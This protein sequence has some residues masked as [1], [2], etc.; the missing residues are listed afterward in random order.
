MA[1]KYMVKF[2][3]KTYYAVIIEAKTE[4]EAINRVESKKVDLRSALALKNST[5]YEVYGV[6]IKE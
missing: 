3:V 2:T 6:K 5:K 1:K 4:S